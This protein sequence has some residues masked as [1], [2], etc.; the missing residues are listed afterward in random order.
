M[1]ALRVRACPKKPEAAKTPALGALTPA[2]GKRSCSR[3]PRR[4]VGFRGAAPGGSPTYKQTPATVAHA[5]PDCDLSPRSPGGTRDIPANS[6]RAESVAHPPRS[7]ASDAKPSANEIRAAV[8]LPPNSTPRTR[9][10]VAK[11]HEHYLNTILPAPGSN[12]SADDIRGGLPAR[13]PRRLSRSGVATIYDHLSKRRR[14]RAH[15]AANTRGQ[16]RRG[17]DVGVDTEGAVLEGAVR[18]A[19]AGTRAEHVGAAQR[20]RAHARR[21]APRPAGS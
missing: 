17:V 14:R 16:R 20:Q 18:G 4:G 15:A 19:R 6:R 3:N 7:E 12:S 2:E 10:T 1:V 11:L 8:D 9:P 13:N 5:R 21:A